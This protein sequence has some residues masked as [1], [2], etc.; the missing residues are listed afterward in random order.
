MAKHLPIN[1]SLLAEPSRCGNRARLIVGFG[2][3][4]GSPE[5]EASGSCLPAEEEDQQCR[6]LREGRQIQF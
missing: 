3:R 1:P 6:E 2:E 4:S 5:A